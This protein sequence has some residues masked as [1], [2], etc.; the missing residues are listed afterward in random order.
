MITNFVKPKSKKTLVKH[1]TLLIFLK[2]IGSS[3][4]P[5]VEWKYQCIRH[6]DGKAD[7][8]RKIKMS[9]RKGKI[10]NDNNVEI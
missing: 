6:S 1:L 5:F 9:E 4:S 8:D 3:L 10:S 7:F 2:N